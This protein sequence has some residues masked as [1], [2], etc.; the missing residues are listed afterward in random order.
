MVR[1]TLWVVGCGVRMGRGGTEVVASG[2]MVGEPG[3]AGVRSEALGCGQWRE[4]LW[5][6]ERKGGG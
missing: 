4:D 2:L 5:G 3:G 6:E 1:A